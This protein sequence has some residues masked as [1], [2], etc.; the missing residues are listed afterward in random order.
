MLARNVETFRLETGRDRPWDT[1]PSVA[2]EFGKPWKKTPSFDSF[3]SEPV[4]ALMPIP[5]GRWKLATADEPQWM[6]GDLVIVMNLDV[7]N[8]NLRQRLRRQRLLRRQLLYGLPGQ[9]PSRSARLN[10][11]RPSEFGPTRRR[12]TSVRIPSRRRPR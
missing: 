5:P 3:Y 9:G 12:T 2:P 10:H 8:H 1:Q 6:Q 4:T 11:Q 7:L